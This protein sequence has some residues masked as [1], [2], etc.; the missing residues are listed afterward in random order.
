MIWLL[1]S[2][3]FTINSY[4]YVQCQ[5]VSRY[6]P[7]L[8]RAW[9]SCMCDAN[10]RVAGGSFTLDHRTLWRCH[11]P[12]FEIRYHMCEYNATSIIPD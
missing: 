6:R 5:V 11:K 2:I 3:D 4:P 12:A 1:I 9:Y 7:S 8:R 10:V